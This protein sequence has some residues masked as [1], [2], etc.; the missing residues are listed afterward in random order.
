[1]ETLL[2]Y[3][4]KHRLYTPENLKTDKGISLEIIDPGI[5]NSD[6]GPDFFNAKI[7]LEGKL[8]AGNIEIHTSSSDWYKHKHNLDKSYNSVI[9]HVVEFADISEIND[10]T[11]RQIP[12]WIIPVPQKIK[13][14]YLFLLNTDF[15]IPCI[16]QL[17]KIPEIYISDWKTALLMERLERKTGQILSLLND[18][19][20]NWNEVFF[21]TMA[22]NF[23]FN[24]NNDAFERL[25]K[26]LP[27][28]Y[29]LKHTNSISQIEA[30]FLGQSGLLNDLS[31]DDHY[32][33]ILQREYNF[34]SRKYNLQGL[35]PHIF[36]NLR[37]R[38]SNS[39]CIKIVQLAGLVRQQPSLLSRILET[40][41][42]KELQDLFHMKINPYWDTHY[43]FGKT[44]HFRPKVLG[45][46]AINILIINV[47]IPVLL[48]YGK[49][50]NMEKYLKRALYLLE[51]IKPE[52]N[53]IV[54]LFKNHGINMENAGDSQAVIQLKR[55]YC[56]KK[57]CIF[58]RI[59]HKLLCK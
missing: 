2:H 1:M 5:S 18:Y 24:T 23:G 37:I 50:K 27:L 36:K 54:N 52:S 59:G 15:P 42:L 35:E 28:K 25:A 46:P 21:L 7:K 48:A 8:W 31:I 51:V 19:K 39:P 55:E 14:N 40:E 49:Q 33:F 56:D 3:V 58:C 16:G 20:N 12:Q 11:G 29:I 57:K 9:L 53:F 47:V 38:P 30:L 26:S 45:I 43:H 41:Q 10:S 34:F 32:Y 6:A 13:E 4:W 22:R 17:Y 44:S